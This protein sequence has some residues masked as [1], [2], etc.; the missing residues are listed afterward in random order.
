[1]LRQQLNGLVNIESMMQLTGY[2]TCKWCKGLG[3]TYPTS[4]GSIFTKTCEYCLG[5]GMVPEGVF[6]EEPPQ[7]P[8]IG[9]GLRDDL[10]KRVRDW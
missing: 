4:H 10:P 9:E 1:M 8:G 2:N 3:T 6:V 5:L 7:Q